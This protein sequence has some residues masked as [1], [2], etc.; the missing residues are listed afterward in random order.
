MKANS[1]L[2]AVAFSIV[3]SLLLGCAAMHSVPQ[4]RNPYRSTLL[5]ADFTSAYPRAIHDDPFGLTDRA[6]ARR[7]SR[8]ETDLAL[9][10]RDE[11][12]TAGRAIQ[13]A[14]DGSQ[15][16]RPDDTYSPLVASQYVRAVYQ[17]NETPVHGGPPQ[18]EL[19]IVDI[20]RYTQR[21][22]RI[23]H[24]TRPAVGDLVFFHNTF[25]RNSDHRNN[26]W[27]THIGVV[28]SVDERGNISVLSY[29]DHRVSRTYLNLERPESTRDADGNVINTTMR[30]RSSD[31]PPY[32][33]YLASELFAG[34]GS[35][36]GDRPEFL[37]IDNWRP[38]MNV[39]RL[40]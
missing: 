36:L 24:S 1:R 28:E 19:E 33:Q 37:V 8:D 34:F 3:A 2:A 6:A 17:A 13:P 40:D 35:L 32:T 11:D 15:R 21:N 31:D 14:S 29:L 25:D 9:V 4:R 39:A 27:Y 26:D 23:Y 18:G 20:Y 38:G 22:G 5:N 10:R 7:P 30:R 16:E 12:Q